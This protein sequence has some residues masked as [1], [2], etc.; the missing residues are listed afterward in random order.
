MTVHPPVAKRKKYPAL[1]LSVIHAHER[2]IPA[3]RD[4]IRWKLL[5]DLPVED[6][7]SAIEKLD[8]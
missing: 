7:S 4:P 3:G 2:G 1:S 6:L 8:W 5:T